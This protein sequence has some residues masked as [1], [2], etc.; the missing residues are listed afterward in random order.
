M[1]SSS[2]SA[3]GA[4]VTVVEHETKNRNAAIVGPQDLGHGLGLT[5]G[6]PVAESRCG[7]PLWLA[8]GYSRTT[9]EYVMHTLARELRLSIAADERR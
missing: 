1:I 5:R 3:P 4:I 6:L 8:L 9:V 2:N 7:K